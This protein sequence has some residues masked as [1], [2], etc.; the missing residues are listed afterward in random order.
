MIV[1]NRKALFTGVVKR[2]CAGF[3]VLA[4]VSPAHGADAV[5][6]DSIK[7]VYPLANGDFVL[8]LN[9]NPPTCTSASN[10]KYLYVSAGENGVTAEGVKAMLATSL[11]AALAGKQL[12]VVF[13][14][15]TA[16]CYVNR[17]V[18]VN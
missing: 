12:Q 6:V 14:D 4:A 11:A 2:L 3:I 16:S 13:S 10:P 18:L 1:K 7:Y 15:A 5:A 17:M 9:S 8:V